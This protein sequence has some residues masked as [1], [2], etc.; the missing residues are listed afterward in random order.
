MI[1]ITEITG[2]NNR[3]RVIA[4]AE[5]FDDAKAKVI[6]M[7]VVHMED[8]ADYPNCADA[9][10]ADGRVLAI[11]PKGFIVKVVA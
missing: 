5:T 9:Y 2:D 1:E 8:D 7:G 6:A 3:R 10:L 4:T 11:Q